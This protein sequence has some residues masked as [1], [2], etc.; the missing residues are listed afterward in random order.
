MTSLCYDEGSSLQQGGNKRFLFT[1]INTAQTLAETIRWCSLQTH[2][3]LPERKREGININPG[4]FLSKSAPLDLLT[5]A[6][7]SLANCCLCAIKEC[8]SVSFHSFWVHENWFMISWKV[9]FKVAARRKLHAFIS[10]TI[11]NCE[12]CTW[13][14]PLKWRGMLFIFIFDFSTQRPPATS[15]NPNIDDLWLSCHFHVCGLTDCAY[16]VCLHNRDLSLLNEITWPCL[17]QGYWFKPW[18]KK[19]QYRLS[20]SSTCGGVEAQGEIECNS[21]VLDIKEGGQHKFLR[22][23][24]PIFFLGQLKEICMF[25]TMA[26]KRA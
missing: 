26:D 19:V 18:I 16:C 9:Y 20:M 23:Y 4:Y 1:T 13:N 6:F 2:Y 11:H 10:P 12:P 21:P 24:I 22:V 5:E 7:F 15:R 25:E 14:M 17:W 3:K 8:Y